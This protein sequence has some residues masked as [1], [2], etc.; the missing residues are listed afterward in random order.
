MRQEVLNFRRNNNLFFTGLK[1]NYKYF[2]CDQYRAKTRGQ[3]RRREENPEHS[4]VL[5]IY[6]VY[7]FG[8]LQIRQKF[9]ILTTF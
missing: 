9:I 5:F 7:I 8:S 6:S 2:H 4:G 3:K 1:R